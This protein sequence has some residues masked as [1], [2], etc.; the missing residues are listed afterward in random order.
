TRLAVCVSAR[1]HRALP[2]ISENMTRDRFESAIYAASSAASRMR[3]LQQ[4]LC[5]KSL[6]AMCSDICG[7]SSDILKGIFAND[8]SE[9]ESSKGSQLAR[10]LCAVSVPEK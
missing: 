7:N 3:I 2:P 8:I 5:E 1:R 9:F 10:S 6:V 4:L